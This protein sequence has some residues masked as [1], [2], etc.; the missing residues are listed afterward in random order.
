MGDAFNSLKKNL[1]KE[2]NT[3]E[4]KKP[5]MF[6]SIFNM[7]GQSDNS[8][9]QTDPDEAERERQKELIRQQ[10]AKNFGR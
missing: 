6:H 2:F 3:P 9:T 10:N 1:K 5:G 7:L 4:D 8:A